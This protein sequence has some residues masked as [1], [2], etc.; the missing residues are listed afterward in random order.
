MKL[1]ELFT[2]KAKKLLAI[3]KFDE[4]GFS[5]P[6]AD[7]KSI[8]EEDSWR[9]TERGVAL[10]VY[11]LNLEN[12]GF[13]LILS[14]HETGTIEE[15]E[16]FRQVIFEGAAKAF[17]EKK[18]K[19]QDDVKIVKMFSQTM[20]S[21]DIEEGMLFFMLEN[22]QTMSIDIYSLEELSHDD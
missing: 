18:E 22:D 8:H 2:F 19:N 3:C 7:W 1:E 5:L 10:P 20:V 4:A 9:P 15:Q 11:R 21:Y 16:S 17:W 6:F 14:R 12:S 13:Y